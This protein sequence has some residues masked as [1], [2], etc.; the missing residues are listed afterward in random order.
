MQ[1]DINLILKNNLMDGAIADGVTAGAA[2]AVSKGGK[3]AS[4]V[5]MA[6]ASTGGT[7][8]AGA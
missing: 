5:S 1:I 8:K 7:S 2:T 3:F 4:A 6:G